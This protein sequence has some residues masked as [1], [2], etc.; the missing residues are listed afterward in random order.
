MLRFSIRE[1]LL[2]TVIVALGFGWWLHVR[3]ERNDVNTLQQRLAVQEKELQRGQLLINYLEVQ[4]EK[5][6]D[7]SRKERTMPLPALL[8]PGDA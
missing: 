2:L 4:V 1:I 3:R 8:N 7:E 6:N 5:L